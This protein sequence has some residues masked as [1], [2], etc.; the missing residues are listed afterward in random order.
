MME[1]RGAQQVDETKKLKDVE[2]SFPVVYG[3]MAFWLGKKASEY[4]S[5][6]WTVYVR[7]ATNEDLSVIIKR[8]VFQLHPSFN[9]PTRVVDSP[10]FELSESGWGE[11]EIAIKLFFHSDVC[12][13]QL[14]L[15]H[16]LKLFPEEE[17]GPQSTKK[18]V[19]A[20]S[21]DEIVFYEPTKSF[22]ARV[23]NHPAAIVPRL[24]S[25]LNLPSPAP[26]TH[27]KKRGDTKDHA[28]SQWF[29][30][31]SEADELLKLAAA[32]QQ[33]QAHIAKLRRQL[34]MIDGMPPQ[35]KATS[36]Q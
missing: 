29:M 28:L 15:Y 2:I 7:S 13:K 24:P 1:S 4:N 6:K 26:I 21:Y 14:E 12:D 5:H 25:G 22:F 35:S 9:N 33:V 8:A 30:N 18:P 17:S 11:F 23:Q 10:P 32:R 27:V 20:E 31:F 16:Q 19:V 3:T 36:G 34:S